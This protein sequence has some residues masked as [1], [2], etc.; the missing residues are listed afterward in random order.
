MFEFNYGRKVSQKGDE[1]ELCVS[2]QRALCGDDLQNGFN[3]AGIGTI[4]RHVH[5]PVSAAAKRR[6]ECYQLEQI[7]LSQ[8]R[9]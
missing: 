5:N 9:D 6:K 2:N 4:L 8:H 3:A 1:R 7:R